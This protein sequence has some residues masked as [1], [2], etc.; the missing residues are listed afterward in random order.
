MVD[1]YYSKFA[2]LKPVPLL[3]YDSAVFL[4]KIQRIAVMKIILIYPIKD[5]HIVLLY[6]L[7][8]T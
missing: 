1:S 4:L 6:M 2:G 3:Q 7:F 8:S 5:E